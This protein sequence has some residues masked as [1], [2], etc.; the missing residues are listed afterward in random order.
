[1]LQSLGAPQR[2]ELSKADSSVPLAVSGVRW[3]P[4]APTSLKLQNPF[5]STED[6]DLV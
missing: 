3:Y 5:G 6:V 4:L 1:M 2:S